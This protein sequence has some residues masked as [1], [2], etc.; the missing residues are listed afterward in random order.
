MKRNKTTAASVKAVFELSSYDCG[1]E[2]I[3][4]TTLFLCPIIQT[5]AYSINKNLSLVQKRAT[6]SGKNECGKL[7]LTVE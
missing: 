1:A 2:N 4:R 6:R 3:R 7:Y 5:G